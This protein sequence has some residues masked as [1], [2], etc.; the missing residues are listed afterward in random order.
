MTPLYI[1]DLDGPLPLIVHDPLRHSAQRSR[2]VAPL[3]LASG[4]FE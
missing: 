2:D 3:H 1:F 4:H